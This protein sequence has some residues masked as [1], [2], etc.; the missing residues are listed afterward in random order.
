MAALDVTELFV[1]PI[2]VHTFTVFRGTQTT[3]EHGWNEVTWNELPG[4][5]GSVQPAGAHS[6]QRLPDGVNVTGAIDIFTNFQF[7]LTS[8]D[9]S[10]PPD[11]VE[12]MGNRYGIKDIQPWYAWGPGWVIATCSLIDTEPGPTP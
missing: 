2:F 11:E 5:V 9:A 1:D 12:W 6:L 4:I 3:N 8:Q 7:N 10:I